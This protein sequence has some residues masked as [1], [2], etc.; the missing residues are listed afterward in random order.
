MTAEQAIN[1]GL[2]TELM[3]VVIQPIPPLPQIT[4]TKM[5][6]SYKLST[7]ENNKGK[8]NGYAFVV[9]Q[10]YIN[11]KSISGKF[12][13][14]EEFLKFGDSLRNAGIKIKLID[15]FTGNVKKY[16][17]QKAI[18]DKLIFNVR[19]GSTAI[20]GRFE[21]SEGVVTVYQKEFK[22]GK[23]LSLG[24]FNTANDLFKFIEESLKDLR[25]YDEVKKMYSRQGYELKENVNYNERALE[26]NRDFQGNPEKY[27]QRLENSRSKYSSSRFFKF[28]R[29]F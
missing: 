11:A 6:G 1:A 17:C 20:E 10:D 29:Q 12:T 2:L 7:T 21:I 24:A 16:S 26:R 25:F 19:E 23:G 28:G 4:P 5:T 8:F 27:L 3:T 22:I 9:N 13:D 14:T 18:T 15:D